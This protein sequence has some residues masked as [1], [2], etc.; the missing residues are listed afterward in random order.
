MDAGSKAYNGMLNMQV[1]TLLTKADEKPPEKPS[2][3]AIAEKQAAVDE[4]I[5]ELDQL[6]AVGAHEHE[7]AV[8]PSCQTGWQGRCFAGAVQLVNQ[9]FRGL[10]RAQIIPRKEASLGQ[11]FCAPALGSVG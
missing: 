9:P 3:E 11:R 7:L 1:T 4:R 5:A 6:R 8:L 2:A 10:G